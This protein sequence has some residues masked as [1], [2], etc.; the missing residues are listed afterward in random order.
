MELTEAVQHLEL[1][2]KKL[3]A[4]TCADSSL[5]LDAVTV[6]PK[7]TSEGRGVALSI[8][9]GE[10]QKLM[11]CP[12]TKALLEELGGHLDELDLVH[13]REVEEL[14]RS[15]DQLTRIPADEYMAYSELT[16]RASDVWHKA[17]EQNDFA[18][19]CP[20]LQELVDYNRKF[21]GY[22]DATKKPYD[23]LL[24]EY[25]RGVD[26]E[27]LDNFFTTLR[28]TIV[29]LLQ[30]IEQKPQIDDSFLHNYYPVDKQKAFADYIM[31]VMGLDRGHCGLSETEHPFT[32]EFNN[33]DVRI[34]TNYDTHNVASSMFSVLHE[35][36][37]AMY[38]LGI[39]DDLQYTCLA[40]GVSMGVHESQSRFFEN[41]IGRS[42]P[43][44]EAIYPKV[45][46]FFPEQLGG[47]SAE[48]FYRAI[49]KAE[50]SLIRTESDEL[51][52]CLHIMVRYEIEKQLIGGT[53]EAK[54]VPAE[55]AKLYKEYLGIDV[56]TD[57]EGC[58]QDS[59]WSGGSFGYFPS[60]ALGNAYG[61]QMLHNM[62]QTVDVAGDSAK[63]DLS[64]I[65]GWLREKVHQ[66]GG[67]MVPADVVKNACGEFDPHYYTDYLTRKYT[68]LYQL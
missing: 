54:D 28:Q 16:N 40:G 15:C 52:Y 21:A 11:T 57:R 9:A 18:S 62:E 47:I 13:R 29:P 12:E 24:N 65:A 45:Q 66:Y 17:K 14:R 44:V 3:Y 34:T 37:H 55:W 50:P 5:Y 48:Q 8:L 20:V 30:K 25:E 67:L 2:Q 63:G 27:M 51:T 7:N 46:E 58:L 59:H 41:L 68:E 36:G 56:P 33:K 38:E 23:A 26:M 35:G 6:A 1:L 22:Y 4:Y 53:L 31:E 61:A 60:Y 19:F 39:R 10:R 49:N 32:L 42:R 64:H 43:F